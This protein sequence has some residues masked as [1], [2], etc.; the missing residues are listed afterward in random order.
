MILVKGCVWIRNNMT[1]VGSI[2][3][4]N[5]PERM[6]CFFGCGLGRNIFW[7]FLLQYTEKENCSETDGACTIR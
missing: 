7:H 1:I 4:S 2:M 5:L 3:A 6:Y